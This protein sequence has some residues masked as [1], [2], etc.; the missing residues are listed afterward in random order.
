[1][2]PANTTNSFSFNTAKYDLELRAD[3]DLYNGGGKYVSR[4]LYGTVTITKR[5]SQSSTLLECQ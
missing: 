3:D 4:L 1:M 5:F 2:I